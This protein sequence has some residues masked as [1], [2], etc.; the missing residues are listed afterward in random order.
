M[1]LEFLEPEPGAIT[2]SM[3]QAMLALVGSRIGLETIEQWTRTELIVA[4]DWGSREH[5]I[6]SDNRIKRRAKP[7]FITA[8]QE[9]HEEPVEAVLRERVHLILSRYPAGVSADT[10]MREGL[11]ESTQME[12]LFRGIVV[13]WLRRLESDG[14]AREFTPGLWISLPDPLESEATEH[15]H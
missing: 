1:R 5:L 3:V 4:F 6:A 8:A 14:R 11:N 9:A 10:I 7:W 2:P 12:A 13:A 15:E